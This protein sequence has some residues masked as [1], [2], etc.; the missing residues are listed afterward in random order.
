MLIFIFFGEIISELQIANQSNKVLHAVHYSG[1]ARNCHQDKSW[2]E[3]SDPM[4]KY[5]C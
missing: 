1:P 2:S 4:N 5:R 3:V